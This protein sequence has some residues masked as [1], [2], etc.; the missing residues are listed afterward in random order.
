LYGHAPH[1]F[2]IT[3][4]NACSVLDL[5]EWLH[6]RQDL[7]VMLQQQMKFQVDKHC[8]ECEFTVGDMVYLKVQPYVQ[9]SLAPRSF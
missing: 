1:H 4:P 8:S 9:M 2:G 7:T 3:N 6:H 5:A